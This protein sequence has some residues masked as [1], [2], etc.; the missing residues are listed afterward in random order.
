MKYSAEELKKIE[1][2]EEKR[3]I[4]YAKTGGKLYKGL[5]FIGILSWCYILFT[6]ISYLIGRTFRITEGLDSIDNPFISI[7]VTTAIALTSILIYVFRLKISYFVINIVAAVTTFISFA[8]IC[9]VDDSISSAGSTVS[10]YDEGFFGLKKIFYW[11]HGI[12]AFL[13]AIVFAI[14]IFIIL[15]EKSIRK[16]ELDIINKNSYEPQILKDDE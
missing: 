7:S 14:L 11:R 9:R 4:K 10:E 5:F 16:K 12:P 6:S 2:Y 13:M 15:R 1:R 8:G 3:G